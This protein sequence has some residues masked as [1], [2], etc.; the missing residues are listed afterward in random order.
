M[1]TRVSGVS[2]T[3]VLAMTGVIFFLPLFTS[4]S[5]QHI[6]TTLYTPI[7][8]PTT[9]KKPK[10]HYLTRDQRLQIQILHNAGFT[11]IEIF[12]QMPNVTYA[13]LAVVLAWGVTEY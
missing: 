8:P 11:Y 1:V 5:K 12:H 13:Q 4:P 9:P 6:P 2:T 7:M 3:L 10:F